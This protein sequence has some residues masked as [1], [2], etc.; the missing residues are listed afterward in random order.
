MV[1]S[2]VRWAISSGSS[3]WV[4]L[5][6]RVV[7]VLLAVVGRGWGGGAGMGAERIV[8][9]MEGMRGTVTSRANAE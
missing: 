5:P 4:S 8:D 6:L 9:V 7:V 2:E 3:G 1:S